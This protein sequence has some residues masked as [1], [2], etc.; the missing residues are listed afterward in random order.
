M[1]DDTRALADHLDAV[2]KEEEFNVGQ[3]QENLSDF[4]EEPAEDAHNPD[5]T[6]IQQSGNLN[7]P[8]TLSF[9]EEH[10]EAEIGTSG[11]LVHAVVPGTSGTD[12]QQKTQIDTTTID[13]NP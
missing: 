11:T 8:E 7:I 9:E 10:D 5:G 4:E 1:E 13:V 3:D 6:G 2:E 12:H